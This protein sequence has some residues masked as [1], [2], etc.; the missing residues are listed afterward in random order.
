MT[1]ESMGASAEA[2]RAFVN[3][4]SDAVSAVPASIPCADLARCMTCGNLAVWEL[5]PSDSY[6]EYCDACVPRGCSCNLIDFAN[7][8]A[9]KQHR[10]DKGRLLPCCEYWFWEEGFPASPKAKVALYR[11][12]IA[13][14]VARELVSKL[15]SG[16]LAEDQEYIDA[17]SPGVRQAVDALYG[18]SFAAKAIEA[19]RAETGT[20]SVED[21]SAVPAG[22]SPEP[23]IPS[24]TTKEVGE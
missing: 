20:G 5:V 16:D 18:A 10:D 23:S 22:H 6:G 17:I 24:S 13:K 19:R 8:K 7:P 14:S 15:E 2:D 11:F 12:G 21:E 3:G 1:K 4:A 9:R